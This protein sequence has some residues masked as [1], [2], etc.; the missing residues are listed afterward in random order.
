MDLLSKVFPKSVGFFEQANNN[1]ILQQYIKN[2][3]SKCVTVTTA[4]K[5]DY[6]KFVNDKI[7]KNEDGDPDRIR[8]CDR[9]I[10]NPMLYPAELRGHDSPR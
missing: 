9:R 10:R 6:F 5:H 3:S 4:T 2:K 1:A 7:I 8:T